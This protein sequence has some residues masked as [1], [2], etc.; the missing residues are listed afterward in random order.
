MRARQVAVLAT[1]LLTV[2]LAGCEKSIPLDQS[3]WQA[4]S[5]RVGVALVK[6]PEPSA[7]RY[8]Q[9]G[10]LDLAINEALAAPLK[11]FLRTADLVPF[12]T[13][14]ER[15]VARLNER[16][17]AARRLETPL[18]L[19]QFPT[20]EGPGDANFDRDL[21]R[22]AEAEGLDFL[23]VLSIEAVGTT[24]DYY[25][26]IPLGPPRA[27][28]RAKGRLVDLRSNALR[29]QAFTAGEEA[30]VRVE[31]DW[32]QPP[33]YPNLGRALQKA[34]EQAAEFLEKQFF[35]QGS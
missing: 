14:A 28:C 17:F 13:R 35:A 26:F 34:I 23:V 11:A 22:L 21:R 32:D 20:F 15:Y 1:L 29:W 16:G 31:G 27:I 25:G 9:E 19:A 6:Y 4:R 10:L 18:D 12:G 7:Y 3:F 5:A 2:A 24:R 33:Q 30:V 8:G